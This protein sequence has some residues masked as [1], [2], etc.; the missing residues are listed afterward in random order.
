MG[1]KQV[2]EQRFNHLIGQEALWI[3]GCNAWLSGRDSN[4]NLALNECLSI[5]NL[6]GSRSACVS[7]RSVAVDHIAL[8]M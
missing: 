7:S 5:A 6:I 8:V 4:H 2:V 3:W 1:L